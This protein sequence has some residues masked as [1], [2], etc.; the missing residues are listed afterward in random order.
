MEIENP[1]VPAFLAHRAASSGETIALIHDET[2]ISYAE[3]DR[4]SRELARRLVEAGIGKHA[5]IAL[6]APNGIDW[7][8]I[9]YAALR[10]GAVLVPLS[11]LLRPPEL[12]AQL[13]LASISHLIASPGYRGRD[14][15]AE[16]ESSVPGI[17]EETKAGRRSAALPA[18][19]AI[20]VPTRSPLYR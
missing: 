8:V 4:R 17:V 14:Y 5:R 6:L 10:V 9:A 11:T 7:A 16:L 2:S 15:F 20:W 13:R 12:V 3:L 1:T 19:Q 18:L